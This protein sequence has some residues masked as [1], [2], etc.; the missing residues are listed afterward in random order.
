MVFNG[1][2]DD[3]DIC[4]LADKMVGSNDVS[5]PLKTKALYA[6]KRSREVWRTIWK[7]Y[8]G[9]IQDDQNN[10]GQPELTVAL[11]TTPRNLY[12]FAAAQAIYGV[13]W[14]DSSGRWRKLKK[15]TV[16]KIRDK[17]F[18]ETEFMNTPGDPMY[19]RPVQNG[20]RLYPD[21][22]AAR[23]SALKAIIKRDIISFASTSTTATPGWDSVLHEGL[24]IGMALDHAKANNLPA[25]GGTLRGGFKTGLFGDW[26][27]YLDEVTAHYQTKFRENFPAA[28][29]KRPNFAGQF[30]S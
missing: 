22:S 8:G 15:I 26:Y 30:V 19:Y 3:Q 24:A 28:I 6:N 2:S 23:A 9:W 11:V 5:F 7:A 1:D 20:V 18:A 25:A 4:T 16:E 14:L 10:S 29:R 27:D 13:E 12:A 17:G 21:S